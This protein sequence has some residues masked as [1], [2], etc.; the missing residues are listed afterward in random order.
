M[1]AYGMTKRAAGDDDVAGCRANGRKTSA[2]SVNG[3]AYRGLR[4]GKKAAA[5]R[6]AKRAARKINK[7][8]CNESNKDA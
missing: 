4:N 6:H 7:E 3:R 2:Y 5:R 1:K 8:L